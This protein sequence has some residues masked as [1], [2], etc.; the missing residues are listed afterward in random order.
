MR[1]GP[2]TSSKSTAGPAFV[3]EATA[4]ANV[5]AREY[6]GSIEEIA[7]GLARYEGT[8]RVFEKHIREAVAIVEFA[9]RNRKPWYTR[10]EIEIGFGTACF[11]WAC[12]VPDFLGCFLPDGSVWLE[13]ECRALG[14]VTADCDIDCLRQPRHAPLPRCRVEQRFSEIIASTPSL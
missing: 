1:G 14:D 11:G 12:C 4:L 8:G 7:Q 5:C 3:R 6:R 9:G 2:L 13:A 10:P